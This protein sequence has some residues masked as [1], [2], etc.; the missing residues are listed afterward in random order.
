MYIVVVN[1]LVNSEL[2]TIAIANIDMLQ[3]NYD[4]FNGRM[5]QGTWIVTVNGKL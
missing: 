4:D 1:Y 5:D 3:V 2:S